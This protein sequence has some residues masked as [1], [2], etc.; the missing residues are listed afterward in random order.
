[1]LEHLRVLTGSFVLTLM[2]SGCVSPPTE[3]GGGPTEPIGDPDPTIAP[4]EVR[5]L[6]IGNSLTYTNSLPDEVVRLARS[7][8]RSIEVGMLAFP[9]FSLEEHWGMGVANLIRAEKADF[10]IMQQGPSSL[11]SSAAHLR[12]WSAQMAGVIREAEGE[13][14]LMMVWP[15]SAR[16]SVFDQVLANYSGA[17]DAIGGWF[18]PAGQSWRT[19]WDREPSLRLYG[20]DGFHPSRLGTL[21]AALTVYWSLFGEDPRPATCELP[22]PSGVS[23]SDF[24]LLCESARDTQELYGNR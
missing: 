24:L 23:D 3:F 6:F 12:Y 18:I 22:V 17:A 4:A 10:V 8:D 5:V 15:E 1:M 13:P 9:N 7:D 11:A 16:F 2:L 14:V 20:N 19:A 21:T